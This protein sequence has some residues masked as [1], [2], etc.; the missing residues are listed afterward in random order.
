IHLQDV[1][2]SLLKEFLASG[3]AIAFAGPVYMGFSNPPLSNGV[4]YGSPT[5]PMSGHGMLLVGYDDLAGNTAKGL[6]AFYI[7]NSFGPQW[8]PAQPGGRF[9]ISYGAFQTQLGAAVAY[10]FDPSPL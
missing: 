5:I 1:P 2:Q 9:W 4:F 8:P 6:G 10:P 3:M 7:Q